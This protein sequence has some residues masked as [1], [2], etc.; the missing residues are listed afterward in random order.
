METVREGTESLDRSVWMEAAVNVTKSV[1]EI[2]EQ[3][4]R[5]ASL[6]GPRNLF[7]YLLA[8]E[9]GDALLVDAGTSVTPR[10]A[11]LP[12]LRRVGVAPERVR[13]VVVTHP[14]L[15]HQGG[16][17]GLKDALPNALAA[18]GFADRGLVANPERLV[19]DRYGAYEDE[20]AVGY[21]ATDKRWMRALYGA[22]VT[23][24]VTF[25][26]GE[27]IEL[28]ERRLRA[29]HAPGHSAGHLVL[30]EPAS[31]LL[32]SSDAIH[33]RMCPAADGSPALPPTY[34]DVDPYL[35]TIELVEALEPSQLH[36]GHWPARTGP[37][38][39]AFCAESREFVAAL[40]AALV[41]RLENPAT[42]RELCEHADRA[43]GPFGADPVNLMFVVHGHLR[44]LVRREDV[45]VVD[46]SERPPRYRRTGS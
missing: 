19:T 7:Q 25:A 29:H 15:D 13:F 43:V 31:G 33:W 32:F 22:P 36:S 4:W 12:A 42:L 10:E 11:I 41:E 5:I 38:I 3:T 21:S 8:D 28:G 39:H 30:H 40:D 18:C 16:L 37:E 45:D 27:R 6:I 1:T 9:G 14:D 46:R 24:D 44:R 2:A 17:A 20:H 26:G 23:I 35:E 34:E